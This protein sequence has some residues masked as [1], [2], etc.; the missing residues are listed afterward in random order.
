MNVIFYTSPTYE[1]NERRGNIRQLLIVQTTR[2]LTKNLSSE[3]KRDS[4]DTFVHGEFYED[5]HPPRYL[6]T[7]VFEW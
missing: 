1:L 7:T 3:I 2:D 5:L 6:F 4:G